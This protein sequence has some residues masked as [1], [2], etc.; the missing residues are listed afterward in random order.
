MTRLRNSSC[1]TDVSDASVARKWFASPIFAFEIQVGAARRRVPANTKL[2]RYGSP[3]RVASK[4]APGIAALAATQKWKRI[5]PE[6][7]A[8]YA[9]ARAQSRLARRAVRKRMRDKPGADFGG[10][11]P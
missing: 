11:P 3:F 8:S 9:D 7:T 1:N 10:S 6:A 4:K 5:F 2:G